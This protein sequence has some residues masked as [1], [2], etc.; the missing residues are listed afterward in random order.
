MPIQLQSNMGHFH[1]FNLFLCHND[2]QK[3]KSHD[4]KYN[5]AKY[6]LSRNHTQMIEHCMWFII[7]KTEVEFYHLTLMSLF[8][9][10]FAPQLQHCLPVHL[11]LSR[12][13]GQSSRGPQHHEPPPAPHH[14][15]SRP[16]PHGSTGAL[17]AW[18]EGCTQ[19]PFWQGETA[20]EQF[21]HTHFYLSFP[22]V[23]LGPKTQISCFILLP[24][25]SLKDFRSTWNELLWT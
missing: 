17:C 9:P 11:L 10:F 16:A 4:W 8:F 3:L 6:M 18:T 25:H 19:E 1:F 13:H 15:F 12:A 5:V 22:F 2:S 20:P 24:N 23:P 14:K 21:N 7:L